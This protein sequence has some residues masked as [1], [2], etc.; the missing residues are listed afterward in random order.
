M[1]VVPQN[2]GRAFK[3]GHHPFVPCSVNG[4][5]R[6]DLLFYSGDDTSVETIILVNTGN[7]FK[8]HSRKVREVDF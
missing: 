7:A 3:L 5:R 2:K 1:I 8:V 4:D 6:T